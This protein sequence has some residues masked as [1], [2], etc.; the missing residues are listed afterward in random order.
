[1]QIHTLSA[2][3][4][5]ELLQRRELSSVEIVQALI[6]RRRAVDPQV[7]AFVVELDAAAL[8][9]AE[10]AD[11]ARLRGEAL[12]LLHGMP[13]TIKENIDVVGLDS[14]MGVTA[15]RQ[16]PAE[17]DAVTVQALRRAGAIVLGKTNVPQLLLAAE[18]ENPIW[19][20]T[21]NPWRLDR[22][23]GGSSGG[24]AAALAAGMT[25]LGIGTDI[26]GS[27]RIPAHFCGIAGLKPTVDRW[28]NRG[29]V[30]AIPGQE[31]VRAQMGPMARTAADVALLMRAVDPRLVAQLDPAVPP[32]PLPD[33]AVVDLRG[34]RVGVCKNDGF[35]RASLAIE[36]AVEEAAAAL[37]AAGAT[38][39]P[40][41]P[42]ASHQLLYLWLAGISADGGHTLEQALA[43]DEVC[44]QLVPSMK[45]AR[46]PGWLR[47][48]VAWW[49]EREGD[50]RMARLLRSLGEK[51]V[52]ELWQLTADRTLLRREEFDAWA[53]QGL[54][55][56]LLPPHAL[57]AMQLG[58]SGELTLALAYAFRYV[59]LNFPAGVVPVT[60]VRPEEELRLDV[61]D[62]IERRCRDVQQG[63]AGLP[64]G[65]QV[66]ARPWR[67]DLVLAAMLAIETA[68]R[69]R[70]EF[71]QT[72][73]DPPIGALAQG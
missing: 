24:E 5:L 18:S 35:V 26:G 45:A 25:P 71:P 72:P 32:M 12:G 14:T 49:F 30:G 38:L 50:V 1:M 58:T 66:V 20:I 65:V 57:P 42:P 55:L 31:L 47:R 22:S 70:P 63:S 8:A 60:R 41:G 7:R 13:I 53:R 36:R 28:S 62:T 33:P 37:E 54:D 39:V 51:P 40:Y 52:R 27:I 44:R 48:L 3:E 56:V 43:G 10:K 29:S 16:Q 59:M 17:V 64:V 21:H 9:A 6:A 11:T 15:R 19:G 46:L 69:G 4:L 34:L 23:P 61:D 68:A 2:T 67:E 73:V